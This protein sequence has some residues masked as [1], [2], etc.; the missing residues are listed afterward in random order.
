M[1]LG[2]QYSA[3]QTSH[4]VKDD[5]VWPNMIFL[6]T[7]PTQQCQLLLK[8]KRLICIK[9]IHQKEEGIKTK[10]GNPIYISLEREE[11]IRRVSYL[12]KIEGSDSHSEVKQK[13]LY[14]AYHMLKKV[15]S[16]N[17]STSQH[18]QI[19]LVFLPEKK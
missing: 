13:K 16:V 2:P 18:F 11:T 3:K 4:H 1:P 7:L 14:Q 6:M 10:V 12:E 17:M 15:K 9:E 8:T 5:T 19:Y